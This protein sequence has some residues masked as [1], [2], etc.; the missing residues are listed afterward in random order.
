M[1]KKRH[2]VEQIVAIF[3]QAELGLSVTASCSA[4]DWSCEYLVTLISRTHLET[5]LM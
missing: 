5:D 4:S 1:K 3:K 2:S